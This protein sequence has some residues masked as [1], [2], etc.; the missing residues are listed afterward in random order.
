M[1]KYF[2]K[3]SGLTF[4]IFFLII[5]FIYNF[6]EIFTM[7]PQGL[8]QWRQC[9]CLSITS[10]YYYNNLN[11][12][13]PEVNN[14]AFDGTGKTVSDFPIFYYITAILWKIF[15]QHE[16][17]FRI[18]DL[19]IVFAAL[20]FLMK[21]IE[22]FVQDS[23]WAL[24]IPLL[25]FTSPML[26]YYSNNFLM[27]VPSLSFDIIGWC[28]FYKFYKN[29]KYKFLYLSFGSFLLAG[30]LKMTGFMSFG[31]ISF[32]FVVEFIQNFRKKDTEKIFF[33]PLQTIIPIAI[34]GIIVLL[35]YLFAIKYNNTYNRNLFLIGIIPIWDLS[36]EKILEVIEHI[37]VIWIRAYFSK[38][39][40]L[41]AILLTIF[42]FI[43]SK[44]I[45]KFFTTTIILYSL[46]F[47]ASLLFWFQA[48]I[49]H[50]YYL[51]NFLII[52]TFIFATF[53]FTLKNEYP[54][55]FNSII[56]KI[57]LLI[58]LI[59][60]ITLTTNNIDDRYTGWMNSHHLEY[61]KSLETITPY[62]RELGIERDDL[63]VSIPDGSINISL[64]LMNQ[65]GYT[66]FGNKMLDSMSFASKIEQGCKYLI[67]NDTAL[68]KQDYIQ[69][70]LKE[71]IGEYQNINIYNLQNILK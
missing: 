21:T 41:L 56:T 24:L 25:L 34:V 50:D 52:W 12:F 5:I 3:F 38:H 16:Y 6:S 54:K 65:K 43:K 37:R 67:I 69:P 30:L 36:N 15:G 19:A 60:N 35:W 47:I 31:I 66:N 59:Y 14:R 7:R 71:K 58:I 70:F 26:V 23:V 42:I 4:L 40:Q 13:E 20:F 55:I 9:D 32:V 63:V 45:S 27:N 44:K 28:F 68:L 39:L 11:F 17:I 51:I 18:L 64:Y 1:I 61:T 46:G 8:H 48:L 22:D 49:H 29:K 62:L 53:A 57:I 10:N 2:P 33:K